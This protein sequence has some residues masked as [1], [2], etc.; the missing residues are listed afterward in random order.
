MSS[1][2][3]GIFALGGAAAC[4][5]FGYEGYQKTVKF[6]KPITLTITEFNKKVPQEGWYKITGGTISKPEAVCMARISRRR[7]E[8]SDDYNRCA[9][10]ANFYL[11]LH[12]PNDANNPKA[13]TNIVVIMPDSD[14]SILAAMQHPEEANGANGH[15]AG[16]LTQAKEVTGLLTPV[17][18]FSKIADVTTGIGA[19]VVYLRDGTYPSGVG[20]AIGQF[21]LGTALI[22]VSL[23]LFGVRFGKKD[24]GVKNTPMNVPKPAPSTKENPF[25]MD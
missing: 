22:P 2:R 5:F 6:P 11:P 23:L 14:G 18:D 9:S 13:R 25:Q 15:D 7:Y 17:T 1:I 21:L 8:M 19:G 24:K 3:F 16:A 12:D 10:S 4:Y 20:M